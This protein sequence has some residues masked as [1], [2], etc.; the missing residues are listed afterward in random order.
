LKRESHAPAFIMSLLVPKTQRTADETSKMT[1]QILIDA[2]DI[3]FAMPVYLPHER[4]IVSNPMSLLRDF[5]LSGHER[6]IKPVLSGVTFQLRAGDRIGVIGQNGAGKSTLLRLLGGIY[7]PARGRLDV[8]CKPMGLFDISTGFVQEATGIENIHL[9]GFEMG[10]SLAQIRGLIPGIVEFSGLPDSIN[11]PFSSYSSG[12]RLRLAVAIALSVQPDVMLLDEWIGLGDAKFQAK[13]TA[14]MNALV[15][16]ARGLLLASHNDTLL[17]RVCT[18]G[19]VMHQGKCAYFGAI[20]DALNH[21]HAQIA[22]KP[23]VKPVLATVNGTSPALVHNS[24]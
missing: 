12:M 3:G 19:L 23:P 10:L 6:H 14:R 22:P 21:Y 15:D 16:G 24:G 7:K 20:D 18:L 2:R 4:S 9:R 13:V 17:K 8:H 11:K 5:Y 1:G